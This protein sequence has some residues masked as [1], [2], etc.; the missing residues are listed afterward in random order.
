[1]IDVAD[2]D[3]RVDL[4]MRWDFGDTDFGGGRINYV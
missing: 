4:V 3:I 1:L 2:E